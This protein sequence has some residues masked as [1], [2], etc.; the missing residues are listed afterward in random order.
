MLAAVSAALPVR[1]EDASAA[2][3]DVP[4]SLL[5]TDS[6]LPKVTEA[7]KAGQP[8]DILVI[9][10]RSSTIGAD[11]NSAYPARMQAALKDKLP[12]VDGQR[13]RRNTGHQDRRRS[14]PPASLS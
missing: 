12:Q 13:I 8:L 11:A 10:S 1:A 2:G 9:G 7:V 5:E 6:P 4:S 3:C 14:R